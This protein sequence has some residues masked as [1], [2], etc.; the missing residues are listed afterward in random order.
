MAIPKE[1]AREHVETA[2]RMLDEGIE[3]PFGASVDYDLVFRG[4]T[5]PPKA[6]VG[7]ASKVAT[8]RLLTPDEFSGGESRGAANEALR[9]LGFD[10]RPKR[11]PAQPPNVATG[12]TWIEMTKSAHGHGGPGWEFGRFLWSPKSSK[13]GT[14]YYRIMTEP[15]PG[16]VVLHSLDSSFVGQ[17]YV[18]ARATVVNEE[19]PSPGEWRG[20][21]PYYR[22]A[23]RDYQKFPRSIALAA[24]IQRYADDI[25]TDIQ[26]NNPRAYPFVLYAGS[27]IRT[28]QG[29][30]LTRCTP[31]LYKLVREATGSNGLTSTP[32]QHFQPA[33]AE[34]TLERLRA[35]T[36]WPAERLKELI[37]ALTTT[38]LQIVLAGPPGTGKTWLALRLAQFI[39]ADREK[40]V[41]LVQFHPSY[42]YEEF[43]EGL[44]PVASGSAISF[45][46]VKGVISQ[47]AKKSHEDPRPH[48]LVIDEMNRANL[49]K[50]LGELMF[51]LEYRDELIDLQFSKDFALPRN[52]LVIGTMNT[53]DRSIRSIDIALRRRF[54]VFECFPDADVL[55]RY[56]EYHRNEVPSLI[57]GFNK[58]NA[59]LTELLDRHHTIGHTFFMA[60]PM[61]TERLQHLWKRKLEPLIE[62]YFFDQRDLANSFKLQDLWPDAL[63]TD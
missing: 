32:Q 29:G 53:A 49:P 47:F 51:S 58:L 9:S 17:S 37:D 35:E 38:A 20:Q 18:A 54:D 12:T 34:Y 15:N 14:H 45:E 28:T 33:P 13:T 42:T 43:V 57:E 21:A 10:V 36:L 61:T 63:D 3:H 41:R 39:T 62:E 7:L 52:L 44:R 30:Y 22:I 56:Y 40:A 59:R 60:D 24:F 31:T 16:D 46:I 4:R 8:G 25:K 19:P 48:V 55:R 50:V 1:L 27:Q 11:E 26:S 5:Y 2:L 6:V 23:L